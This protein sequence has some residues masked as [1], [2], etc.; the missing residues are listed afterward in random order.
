MPLVDHEER[1]KYQREYAKMRGHKDPSY[2]TINNRRQ[3]ARKPKEYML[4]RAKGRCK[5]TDVPITITVDDFE[6][7][8]FCPVFPD[9]RLRFAEGRGRPDNIPTLDRIIPALGYIPGNVRVISMRANRLKS[10][11][12]VEELEAIIAYIRANAPP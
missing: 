7:P 9:I 3:R 10:D 2:H 8:E 4:G 11:A 12:T 1:K 6:I 5:G